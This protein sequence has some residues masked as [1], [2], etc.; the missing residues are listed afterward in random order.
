MHLAAAMKVPNQ[1]VIE[2]PTLNPT[3]LPFGNPYRIVRN[4]AVNGQN[5]DYYCY[6]GGPIKGN[7][8]ELVAL[9]SSIT[10]ESVLGV[11]TDALR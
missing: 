4:P 11:L 1:I 8:E 2:A 10:V 9:M 5:L 6:D 3:N 7:D